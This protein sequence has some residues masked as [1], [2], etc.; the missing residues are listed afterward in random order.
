MRA[1]KAAAENLYT[2]D[3]EKIRATCEAEAQEL[4]VVHTVH[5]AEVEENLE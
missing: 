4:R 3:V 1:A 5:P 2:P